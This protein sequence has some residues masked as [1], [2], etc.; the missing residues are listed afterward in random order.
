MAKFSISVGHGPGDA[1]KRQGAFV[2]QDYSATDYYKK[3]GK[4]QDTGRVAIDKLTGHGENLRFKAN[5]NKMSWGILFGKSN[6][7]S[8]AKL[9]NNVK[10][11]YESDDKYAALDNLMD[12]EKIYDDALHFQRN[13][14]TDWD[15]PRQEYLKQVKEF[16]D[17]YKDLLK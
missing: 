6:P 8:F 15:S 3:T 9:I 12:L 16:I 5:N 10:T 13:L 14:G 2:Q 17:K 7:N 4:K 1:S 11:S